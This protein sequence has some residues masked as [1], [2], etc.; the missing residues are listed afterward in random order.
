MSETG[1]A[2]LEQLG[3]ILVTAFCIAFFGSY[4]LALFT[5]RRRLLTAA[6]WVN[7]LLLPLGGSAQVRWTASS[8]FHITGIDQLSPFNRMVVTVLL[9]PRDLIASLVVNRLL[10]RNDLL[11]VRCE[12]RHQPI[13]GLEIYRP[14]TLLSGLARKELQGEQWTEMPS[15]SSDHLIAHGGGKAADLS[16]ALLAELGDYR[17]HLWRLA[18]RRHFPHILVAVDLP[19]LNDDEARRFRD[20]IQRL[21]AALEPYSTVMNESSES[22]QATDS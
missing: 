13:W 21:V 2:L 5:G 7:D 4:A 22:L 15:G 20:L 9:K 1:T 3:G 11:L 8:A 17:D 16:D 19:E 14:R 10:R 12:L 6:R 18:V